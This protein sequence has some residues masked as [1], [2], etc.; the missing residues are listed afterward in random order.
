[1]VVADAIKLVS[2][3]P[4]ESRSF[5]YDYDQNGQ[6]TEL[7]DTNPN[8]QADTFKITTD[9]LARTTQV[10]ELKA[11]QNRAT[12]DYTYDLNSN[13]LS[14]HAQRPAG[15]NNLQVSPLY[16]LHV[17]CPEPGGHRQGG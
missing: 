16:R 11:T 7:K 8:A 12:T 9:G 1:M 2:T 14:T 10:Q 5:T 4:V 17:G 3:S 13:V 6:Q 15:T